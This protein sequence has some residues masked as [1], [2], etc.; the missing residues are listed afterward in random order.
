M[1]LGAVVVV[2]LTLAACGSP[3]SSRASSAPRTAASALPT[4]SSPASNARQSPPQSFRTALTCVH[5]PLPGNAL[6]L[7]RNVYESQAP[8]GVLDV[9]VPTAPVLDCAL[10][11]ARGGRFLSATRIAFWTEDYLGVADLATG[12]VSQTAR[13]PAAAQNGAFSADGTAF[14]YRVMDEAGGV[15]GHLLVHGTDRTLYSQEPVG[16]HG[17]P[18]PDFGPYDQ[19]SFSADGTEFLDYMLFR[20]PSGP[21][22]LV[23]YRLDGSLAFDLGGSIGVWAATGHSLYFT[24]PSSSS[25]TIKE[26][27]QLDSQGLQHIVSSRLNGYWWPVLSPDGASIVYNVPDNSVPDCGGL[28]HLWS[29]DLQMGSTAE[30]SNAV[31]STPAFVGPMTVWSNEERLGPCGLGGP[32][33]QTGMILALDLKTGAESRV[34][35]S[36][37]RDLTGSPAQYVTSAWVL[38]IR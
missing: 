14:A 17:G 2:L 4:Y 38:D 1:K 25:P 29:V 27:D 31:S 22:N 10:S 23:V 19:M 6:A 34:D 26:L 33:V 8:L 35:L 30:L 7:F 21:S 20:P 28:P 15:T 16:G 13:L 24:L 37:Y 3:T 11:P 5:Q 12:V 9:S 18:G 32:S 36:F